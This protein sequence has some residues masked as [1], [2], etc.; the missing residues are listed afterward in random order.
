LID[1]NE[2]KIQDELTFKPRISEKLN[3]KFDKPVVSRLYEY[4]S[5]DVGII[6]EELTIGKF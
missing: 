3:F 2:K 1:N 5:F 6:K 4:N